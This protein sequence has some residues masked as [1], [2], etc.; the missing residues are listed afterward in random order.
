MAGVLTVGGADQIQIEQIFPSTQKTFLY[1]FNAN[2][3]GWTFVVDQ[4]TLILDTIAFDR[5]GNPSFDNSKVVGYFPKQD[6]TG[7]FAPTVV[8]YSTGSVKIT[9]PANMYSG[10]II[11]DARFDVPVTVVGV[12]W[13]D[14]STPKQINTHRW[15]FIQNW[16]P[17]VQIGDPKLENDFTAST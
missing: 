10:A 3:T 17:G 13:Q 5:S 14:N 7:D 12:T 1:N 11:P 8:N 15:A 9:I 4:Q 16:E 6:I 2:V